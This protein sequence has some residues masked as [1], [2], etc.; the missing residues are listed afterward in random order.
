MKPR[1]LLVD[2]ENRIIKILSRIL[3][4]E[5]YEL[6]TAGSGETGLELARKNRP[7]IVLMDLNLPGISGMEAMG[8]LHT[9]YPE[10]LVIMITAYGTI[11]SAVEAMQKGAYN[12]ISKPFDNDALLMI[13]RRAEEHLHLQ[14]QVSELK[15]QIEERYSFANIIGQSET[16]HRVFNRMQ[17]VARTDATV[18]IQGES[19]TGKELIVRAI[20]QASSRKEG[21]FIPVNCGAIPQNLVESEFFGHEKGAFTDARDQRIGAFERAENGTLFLDEIGELPLETQ[22]KLLRAIETRSITRVGGD[23][24][25]HVNIRIVAATNR[26]LETEVEAGAFRQD[27]F[28][29]LNVFFIPIPPLRERQGDIPLLVDCFLNKHVKEL[30]SPVKRI[31]GTTISTLKAYEWPG[32]I[33]ELENAIQSA[34]IVCQDEILHPHHLPLR[35]QGYSISD[36]GKDTTSTGLEANVRRITDDVER[37]L[38]LKALSDNGNN[39]TQAAEKLQISRKTLFNKMQRLGI[40]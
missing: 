7:D 22:V 17:R 1:L 36:T 18:L 21:P 39:K 5:G 2:D 11:N 9:L 29:R 26:L 28:F 35:I 3:K 30:A 38:I 33:R 16:M 14:Q 31:A 12:Y 8:Q 4:E 13:L 37:E 32:N 40:E 10:I 15:D 27:L 24:E 19:G 23:K 6:Y 34:L 20:H 25:I